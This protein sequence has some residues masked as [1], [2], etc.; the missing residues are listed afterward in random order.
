MEK[1]KDEI[2]EKQEAE[3][4]QRRK[5]KETAASIDYNSFGSTSGGSLGA[6]DPVKQEYFNK[7]GT[8]FNPEACRKTIDPYMPYAKEATNI[9]ST[10]NPDLIEEIFM[11]EL[12]NVGIEVKASDKKYKLKFT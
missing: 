3:R 2:F 4:E 7:V 12:K 9:F 1:R 11:K 6:R 10:N 8:I 5:D